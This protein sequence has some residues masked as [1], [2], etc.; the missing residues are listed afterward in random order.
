MYAIL[1]K[2]MQLIFYTFITLKYAKIYWK[3]MF[4]FEHYFEQCRKCKSIEYVS[5]ARR[6]IKLKPPCSSNNDIM[7]IVY[8]G[9]MYLWLLLTY[10][11]FF[12]FF[13]SSKQYRVNKR[14]VVWCVLLLVTYM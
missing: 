6:T 2:N 10:L 9:I 8:V 14:S 3:E 1:F 13:F 11:T 4:K 7:Y 12:S 5:A